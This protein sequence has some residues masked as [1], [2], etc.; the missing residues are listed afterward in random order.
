MRSYLR[1]CWCQTQIH[2]PRC[3]C[4]SS[5]QCRLSLGSLSCHLFSALTWCTWVDPERSDTEEVYNSSYVCKPKMNTCIFTI[6]DQYLIHHLGLDFFGLFFNFHSFNLLSHFF[7]W[8]CP[9]K[10]LQITKTAQNTPAYSLLGLACHQDV[11]HPQWCWVTMCN[12]L[13]SLTLLSKSWL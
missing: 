12:K 3:Q 1:E 4:T 6:L 7:Y 2:P 9:F 8:I 13:P 10:P 11:H 5:S